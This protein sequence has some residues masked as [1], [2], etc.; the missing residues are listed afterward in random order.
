MQ[1]KNDVILVTGGCSGLGLATAEHLAALGNR[2]AIFDLDVSESPKVPAH[3]LI[4]LKTDVTD[5]AL[6]RKNMQAVVEK[7]GRIDAVVNCAGIARAGLM[8]HPKPQHEMTYEKMEFT[9]KINVLGTFNVMKAYTEIYSKNKWKNGVIVNV[10]SVAAEDGQNGQ[11][12]YSASKGAINGMT[13][14]LARELG[15]HGIRI[16]SIMPGVFMT[17]MASMMSDKVHQNI[18][19]SS[20]LNRMGEPPEFALFCEAIL[21]NGYL[22]GVNLRLDGGTRLTKL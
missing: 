19:N 17:N 15:S 13:L 12:A 16:C 21:R 6:V 7:F 4:K 20:S 18:K 5:A 10:S 1:L 3:N 11:C 9:L 8:I 22:T 14:P 2:I